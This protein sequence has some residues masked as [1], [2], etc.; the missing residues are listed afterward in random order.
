MTRVLHLTDLHVVAP[1]T[2][3]ALRRVADAVA[4]L[5]PNLLVVSGDLT[6]RGDLESYAQAAQ[7]MEAL[8]LPTVYALGNHDARAAF[9]TAFPG[10]P[11]AAEAPLDHDRVAA[12][13]HVIAL[14]SSE[15]GQVSGRLEDAQIAGLKEMLA[16]HPKLPKLL[17]VHHPPLLDPE[18]PY[19]WAALSAEATERL[20]GALRGHDVRAVL[21]GHIHIDRVALWEGIPLVVNRGLATA[22]DPTVTEGLAIVEG[23]SMAICDLL[24]GGLQVTF[25]PMDG[26]AEI[27]ALPD[28]MV[29]G[30]A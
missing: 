11:G 6:D 26:P 28:A 20:A 29:R 12:G 9:R 5:R 2:R 22:I 18:A 17:T 1:E 19:G 8:A 3:P 23:A 14:D 7:A 4:R 25:A 15:P 21:S 30:F 27:K 24:P 13:L 10:H 16:R